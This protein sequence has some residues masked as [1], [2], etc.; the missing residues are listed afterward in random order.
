MLNN[1]MASNMPT[2]FPMLRLWIIILV[3]IL[4]CIA[5]VHRVGHKAEH[6][7]AEAGR[8]EVLTVR[9]PAPESVILAHSVASAWNCS[10]VYSAAQQQQ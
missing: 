1:G 6:E 4:T 3:C 5:A 10:R 2:L 7:N 9:H 8:A